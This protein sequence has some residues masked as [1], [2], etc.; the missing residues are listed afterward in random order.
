M[1]TSRSRSTTTTT[2]FTAVTTDVAATT[3]ATTAQPLGCNATNAVN[4]AVVVVVYW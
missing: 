3:I 2:T 4:R 1:S